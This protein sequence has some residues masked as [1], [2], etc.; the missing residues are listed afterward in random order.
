MKIIEI[1]EEEIDAL[2][3]IQLDMRMMIQDLTINSSKQV[4]TE[5]VL[6]L[7]KSYEQLIAVIK[8]K[9]KQVDIS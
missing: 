9:I 6:A 7:V 2:S 5:L 4:S 3:E 8:S 1:T